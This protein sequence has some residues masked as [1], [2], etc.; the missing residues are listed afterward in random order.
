MVKEAVLVYRKSNP[1]NF[2]VA[3]GSGIEKGTILKVADPMTASAS[4]AKNDIVGGIAA[5][6]K[7]ANDGVTELAVYRDGIFR[8]YA[9]GAIT[10]GDPVGTEAAAATTIYNHVQSQKATA[11]LSGML[12]LGYALETASSGE[13]FLIELNI[14]GQSG[15]TGA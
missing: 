15:T 13:Q 2:I 9:S 4:T 1:I 3:D 10:V 6:E 5:C 8:V 12:R 7:I 11:A 14:G